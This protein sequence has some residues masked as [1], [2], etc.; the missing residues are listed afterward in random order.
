MRNLIIWAYGKVAVF[1]PPDAATGGNIALMAADELERLRA[2]LEEAA[3]IAF[4]GVEEEGYP[5]S[6]DR[7]PETLRNAILKLANISGG[8][9]DDGHGSGG[10]W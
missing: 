1:S 4:N 7:R 3:S 8:Y 5:G 9:A 6:I 2:A 10:A